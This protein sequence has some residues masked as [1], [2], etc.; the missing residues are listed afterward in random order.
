MDYHINVDTLLEDIGPFGLYQK[1][2]YLLLCLPCT[3]TAFITLASVFTA[4]IPRHR[5]RI[6][7]CDGAANHSDYA[8]AFDPARPFANFTLPASAEGFASCTRWAERS[9]SAMACEAG[10]FDEAQ[11]V[12]CSARVYDE[13]VYGPTIVSEFDLVCGSAWQVP[14]GQSVYFGGVLVGALVFGLLADILGRRTCLMVAIAI[15]VVGSLGLGWAPNYVF[16]LVMAFLVAFGQLGIFQ[17]AFILSVEN[18]GHRYR[19]FCSIVIEYFFVA[20]EILL[21]LV[22]FWV[23]DWRRIILYVMGPA[24]L[25][26]LY[27]PFLPE[28]L[29]WLVSQKKFPAAQREV[30]RIARWNRTEPVGLDDYK[31]QVVTALRPQEGLSHLLRSRVLV[32]RSLNVCYCWFVVSLNFY[33]LSMNST[34]LAGD[35]YLNFLLVSLAE[36]PGYTL[37][38]WTMEKL[39]RRVSVSGSLFIGGL[40]CI[41]GPF[42]PDRIPWLSV[43]LFLIGKM[44]VTCAFGTIYLFTSE[45]YP[46]TLRTLGVGFSSMCG[47]IGAI[48]SPE[49]AALSHVAHWLPM[50]IFGTNAIV[51]GIVINFLPETLGRE[52]PETVSDALNL[53][54]DLEIDLNPEDNET[55]D[56]GDPL[57]SRQVFPQEQ[58]VGNG[59]EEEERIHEEERSGEHIQSGRVDAL[60]TCR[61]QGRA[62]GTDEADHGENAP[63]L[64]L[65]HTATGH[66]ADH[67]GGRGAEGG[68]DAPR[69]K[70]P[71]AVEGHWEAHAN[72]PSDAGQDGHPS[73]VHASL[74]AQERQDD[75]ERDQI[76]DAIDGEEHREL[77]LVP[78]VLVGRE[79]VAVRALGSVVGKYVAS[80]VEEE[81]QD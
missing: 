26:L 43:A 30:D 3:L 28:S 67:D 46:T 71:R 33:G 57:S 79:E 35:P 4:A 44:G 81:H 24:S 12:D 77:L 60:I 51:S 5:C 63:N 62:D 66:G 68:D 54:R 10:H 20:G 39:G 7:L 19:V 55:T 70:G 2:F 45:L 13:A 1:T 8:A 31:E 80:K 40:A 11:A 48:L 34:S 27:W 42:V 16:Y 25:F 21:T 41:L 65:I 49:V 14:I 52:L 53:S 69:V 15:T 32:G 59:E 64:V 47:R 72:G 36:I 61:D 6:P 50:V 18:V 37:S 73:V 78:P 58:V 29:R 23:R 22:A 56:H 75:P 74:L 17:T 38:Y 76:E 9:G